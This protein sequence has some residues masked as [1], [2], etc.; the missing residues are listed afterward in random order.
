MNYRSVVA[1]GQARLIGDV[2][3]KNEAL[4]VISEHIVAGRWDEVRQP[5]EQELKA[6]SVLEFSIEEASAKMR[7]GFP[8]DDE[9]DYSL[10]VWAGILPLPVVPQV[11]I[12][13]PRLMNGI[14]VSESVKR[15][16]SA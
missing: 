10:P 12:A 4:R 7:T 5:T 13:D 11:A 1:F 6:T 9:E 16:A 3:Q 14:G 15:R 2:G 8:I